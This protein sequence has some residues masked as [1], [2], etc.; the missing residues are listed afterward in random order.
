MY[1]LNFQQLEIENTSPL[2]LAKFL[3]L[4]MDHI[5]LQLLI[6]RVTMTLELA[7]LELMM[8]QRGLARVTFRN[9][10]L[11]FRI[12]MWPPNLATQSCFTFHNADVAFV[13]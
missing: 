2:E 13:S 4:E 3:Q 1:V 11:E 5:N 9:K 7:S 8:I 12:D 10:R 6:T